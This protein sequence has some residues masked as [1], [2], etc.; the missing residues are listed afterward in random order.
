MYL[1]YYPDWRLG[2][3]MTDRINEEDRSQTKYVKIT[4]QHFSWEN[5]DPSIEVRFDDIF[6]GVRENNPPNKPDI[7][8]GTIKGEAGIDYIY[9]SYATDPDGGT[10]F[11]NF[12]WGDGTY[13]GWIGPYFE[14]ETANASHNWT[15][16]GDYEIRVK[17][18]DGS[19]ESVWSDPFIVTMPKNKLLTI[20][21]FK[22]LLERFPMLY[23]LLLRFL[24]I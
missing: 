7:P 12:S 3:W 2:K 17:A 18:S 13:T 20:S 10:L 1:I 23:K 9:S 24:V 21:I 22:P 15:N 16:E 8:S 4:I 14:W 11:Y 6:F 19:L 5:P